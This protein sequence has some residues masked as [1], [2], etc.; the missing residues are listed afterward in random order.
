MLKKCHKCLVLKIGNTSPLLTNQAENNFLGYVLVKPQTANFFPMCIDFLGKRLF[1]V[2]HNIQEVFEIINL[3]SN[4][5]VD[6][7]TMDC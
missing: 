6:Y 3:R 4:I 1:L 7:R 2:N 5:L